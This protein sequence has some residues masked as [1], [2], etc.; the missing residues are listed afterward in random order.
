MNAPGIPGEL[1]TNL[2]VPCHRPV[3]P[4]LQSGKEV[5]G[6]VRHP[7]QLTIGAGSYTVVVVSRGIVGAAV[8]ALS[9]RPWRDLFY[10]RRP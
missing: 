3:S 2:E 6:Q 7:L 9:A 5:P 4:G 10:S 1:G 8:V